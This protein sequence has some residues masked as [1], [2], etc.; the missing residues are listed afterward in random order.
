MEIPLGDLITEDTLIKIWSL[1]KRFSIIFWRVDHDSQQIHSIS[2]S[3]AIYT[4]MTPDDSNF[5]YTTRKVIY[6]AKRKRDLIL[7]EIA[8]LVLTE[9]NLDQISLRIGR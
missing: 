3:N 7:P 6:L 5:I 1:W 8:R 9:Q 4:I 2:T